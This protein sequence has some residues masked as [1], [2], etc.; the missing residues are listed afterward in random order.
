[1]AVLRFLIEHDQHVSGEVRGLVERLRAAFRADPA[2]TVWDCW[3]NVGAHGFTVRLQQARRV[4]PY[5]GRSDG[6]RVTYSGG[7]TADF[8]LDDVT[9]WLRAQSPE[10]AEAHPQ[11]RR[12]RPAASGRRGNA[13]SGR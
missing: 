7:G 1:M 11:T 13:G 2:E 6:P 4:A 10:Q 9:A 3:A 5:G 8:I 12:S